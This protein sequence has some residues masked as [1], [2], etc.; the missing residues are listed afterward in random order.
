MKIKEEIGTVRSELDAAMGPKK[1]DK[2]SRAQRIATRIFF[3]VGVAGVALMVWQLDIT[4]VDWPNLVRHMP[5]WIPALLLLWAAI[6]GVHALSYRLILGEDGDKVPFHRLYRITVSCFA[7]NN[8]TPIGFMG[9]EPYRILEMTPYVG[10][11]KAAASTVTYTVLFGISHALLWVTGCGVYFL[12]LDAARSVVRSVV[13]ALVGVFFAALSLVVLLSRREGLV[14]RAVNGLTRL[15]FVGKYISRLRDRHQETIAGVDREI[16]FFHRH[17]DMFYMT[18]LLEYAARLMEAV[19]LYM[20]FWF[21]GDKM[22]YAHALFA[23]STAS[24]V[25]NA[26]FVI[27]MQL[28]SR[29]GGAVMAIEWLGHEASLGVSASLLCRIREIVFTAIGIGALVIR[30]KKQE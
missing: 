16:D 29:E 24:L 25:G 4:R 26:L 6:Y 9:G 12:L 18:V 27:P 14:T 10:A 13:F 19:E 2:R 20:I 28:G 11:A 21:L 8:V 1:P 7:I 15:P 30:K 23:L 22:P 3:I 17:R 5:Y